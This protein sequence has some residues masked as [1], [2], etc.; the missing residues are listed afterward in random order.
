MGSCEF[1]GGSYRYVRRV[2][3]LCLFAILCS[4]S[5]GW[6]CST[7]HAQLPAEGVSVPPGGGAALACGADDYLTKIDC[8][9]PN[10]T[11]RDSLDG[12]CDPKESDR[13]PCHNIS[14]FSVTNFT[15]QTGLPTMD[16][17]GTRIPV[18]FGPSLFFNMDQRPQCFYRRLLLATAIT[19]GIA[20]AGGIGGLDF[21]GGV[22]FD[23]AFA[24]IM[25]LM[26]TFDFA[27]IAD[28]I[29]AAQQAIAEAESTNFL[30]FIVNAITGSLGA[31]VNNF[32]QNPAISWT[33]NPVLCGAYGVCSTLYDN[34]CNPVALREAG[35]KC[36]GLPQSQATFFWA[37][38]PISLI[39]E[40]GIEPED[41]MSVVR[42]NL[43]PSQRKQYWL[44]KASG[45]TPL[46]VY[47]PRHE[48]RITSATQLFGGW[49]FGGQRVASLDQS[50]PARP[51]KN[52]FDAL[53]TLDENGDGKI[54][55]AELE[56]LALWFDHNQDAISQPGE[57]AR[58]ERHNISA[59]YYRD[60]LYDQKSE[61]VFIDRGYE[62]TI[63]GTVVE[64]KAVDWFTKGADHPFS[65][66]ADINLHGLDMN[67]S[68]RSEQQ[69]LAKLPA[70]PQEKTDAVESRDNSTNDRVAQS[71]S[72]VWTW[73]IETP[74]LDANRPYDGH[75]IIS[76][77]N[78]DDI[79]LQSVIE[80]FVV[81]EKRIEFSMISRFMLKGAVSG[82]TLT[83]E[84]SSPDLSAKKESKA[85]ISDGHMKGRTTVHTIIEGKTR[86]L[87]YDWTASKVQ[88]VK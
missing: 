71:L 37:E 13:G 55:G 6:F 78:A 45:K 34:N 87:F 43:D 12:S 84:G 57:V 2:V 66:V 58:L 75:F 26:F 38:S 31:L 81:G 20:L 65:L 72:G 48:G 80:S 1:V 24:V 83:F 11:I 62:R 63:D 32:I 82:R 18:L 5:A 59:L 25:S 74:G 52:G 4:S 56:P 7:A 51:W 8:P 64:G 69:P 14:I 68:S 86:K 40:N 42:F 16:I 22:G 3:V 30:E 70:P 79:D 15:G 28:G 17:G 33:F 60:Y 36:D 54:S 10:G 77:K 76:A 73:R 49:T 46:L 23:Q 41:N 29:G 67:K 44:W 61:N 50:E 9:C 21:N 85:E 35:E 53:A 39:M 19:A 88:I 47:D 27:S